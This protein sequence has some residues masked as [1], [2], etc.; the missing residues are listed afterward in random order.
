MVAAILIFGLPEAALA[1]LT[2]TNVLS[3]NTAINLD[4]GVTSSSGGDILWDGTTIT[5]QG[6]ATALHIYNNWPIQ[7][8]NTI[9]SIVVE[10]LPGY[11]KAPQTQ[12]AVGAVFGVHANSGHYAKVIVISNSG[13]SITIEFT[14]FGVTG[15]G[16]GGTGPPTIS[17]IQNNSSLIA[18]GLP[19]YG[20][21]PSSIFVV[22]GSGL[23]DPGAPVL[24]SSA[25]PGLPLTL[26]GASITVVVGGVTV[27]P[28]L[29]YTSPTQLAA[30][31]P[32]AT[33]IGTGTVTVTYKGVASNAA[34]IK[35][36]PAALGINTFYTNSA[37]ATDS[38]SGA[39]LTYTNSGMPGQTIVLW[40]TGLG[41]D[42]ADSD[43]T[44]TTTP[45]A[46]N[47]TVQVY[48]GGIPATLLYAGSAGFPGVD[49]IN[50]TVPATVPNGCWISLAVVAGSVVSNIATLPIN[51]GGGAC[52]DAVSGLNGTQISPGN[53][54]I[55]TGLVGLIQTNEVGKNG[56][57]TITNSA[58]G[59]FEKYAGIY[60]PSN[61]VSPG[62]CIVNSLT[63]VSTG[64]ITGL[65][66]GTI[67]LTGPSSP[68]VTL[69]SQGI[70]YA[71][72]ATL[73][74]GAIPS[75]GGTFIF[76]GSGGP[77]VGP[78][79]ATIMLANPL[80]TWTNQS[81]AASINRSQAL[82]VTWT[83]GNPGTY[84]VITGTSTAASTANST[85]VAGGYTCV[86][87]ADAKQ[88]TV[89]SY[90]LSAL[91][92]GNG[93][94]R[95]QNDVYSAFGSTGLDIGL[96]LGSISAGVTSTYN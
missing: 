82:T 61:S 30:V 96:A 75:T 32:A 29:Y 59:A 64:D 20:I 54:T 37:V 74:D 70:A 88:F 66:P 17:A 49:Q 69:A 65:N 34:A 5:P 7:Q 56:A 67:T 45:H 41:A 16:T 91:P 90:I 2:Q 25:A 12:L 14:T 57:T 40:T 60:T 48:I 13:G 76:Q 73:A 62:G 92:A 8:F 22:T 46:V 94:T 24:Q 77:D 79:S 83:G 21:P 1:D 63:P 84:V 9:S 26:N 87:S 27:H 80:L 15:S 93:G 10:S 51:S 6:N 33:P 4:T 11:S 47:T 18:A 95:L 68:S 38:A 19:N 72:Y 23:A 78:F 53:Q 44:Y 28:A 31:L 58:D 39:L 89:P 42:L 86:A 3:G 55:R 36:V 81:A 85:G 35:V 71:F 43:T 50:V 52:V